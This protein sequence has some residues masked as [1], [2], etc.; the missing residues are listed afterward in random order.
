MPRVPSLALAA[1]ASLALTGCAGF[2]GESCREPQA[3][4]SADSVPSLRIP[5]G[6]SAPQNRGALKIPEVGETA[7][8]RGP[9]E[10][11]LDEPPSFFPGRPKPGAGPAAAPAERKPAAAE[12]TP[13]VKPPPPLTNN[14]DPPKP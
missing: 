8:P 4:Q 11:C 13:A 7:R 12:Q 3:Y 6:L 1:A 9:G 14:D 10:P 2:R 5:D